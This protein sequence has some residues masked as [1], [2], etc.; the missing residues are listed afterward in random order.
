MQGDVQKICHIMTGDGGQETHLVFQKAI[1][2]NRI[3]DLLISGSAGHQ[4]KLKQI[5]EDPY[6]NEDSKGTNLSRRNRFLNHLMS[7]FAEQFT[8]YSL[9]LY[10]AMPGEDAAVSEKIIADKQAFLRDYPLISSGRGMAFDFLGPEDSENISGLERRIKRGVRRF[11]DATLRRTH[12]SYTRR[13][14][15][16]AVSADGPCLPRVT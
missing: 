3:D 8:D 12:R 2:G 1:P 15:A 7:R 10:G 6:S 14:L 4:A 5:T 13:L 11:G 16:S 9:V